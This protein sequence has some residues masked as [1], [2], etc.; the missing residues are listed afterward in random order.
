MPVTNE[1]II[2]VTESTLD[3]KTDE[4]IENIFER[5][6]IDDECRF[7]L[8]ERFIRRFPIYKDLL[9]ERFYESMNGNEAWDMKELQSILDI[10]GYSK[11]HVE[12]Q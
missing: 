5:I 12:S 8:L 9:L 11:Y 6:V 10:F 4:F 1:Q 7:I 3:G 2:R